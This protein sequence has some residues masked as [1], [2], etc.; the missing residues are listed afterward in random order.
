M[1]Q[2]QGARLAATRLAQVRAAGRARSY[3]RTMIQLR[4]GCCAAVLFLLASGRPAFSQVDGVVRD[5]Q[6]D[7]RP[8]EGMDFLDRI[9]ATDRW[10]NFPKFQET[11]EY[12]KGALTGIGLRNVEMISP[13]ADGVTQVGWWTMPLAW[14]VKQATLEIVEPSAPADMRYLA[15]YQ[16]IP[17]SL[18][19]WS[20]PTPPGGIT[21]DVVELRSLNQADI[22]K[23]DLKGKIVLVYQDPSSHKL[24]LIRKGAVG[25][26]S[27]ATENP[28][29]R[30]GHFWINAWGDQGWG[31]IKSSTPLV[32]FSITP[33]Q[34]EYISGILARG[35][36]VRVKAVADTRY[37]AG[38][39]P[40]V[41]GVIPG[42]TDEEVLVLGHT[43]EQGANDNGSG[44]AVMVEAMATLRR[45]IDAGTLKAPRRGIRILAMPE[46]YGSM[47]YIT[48]NPERMR[49]TVAAM[50]LDSPAGPY[51]AAGSEI[52]F[53][54]D[55]DVA[56]SYTDALVL[57]IA[58]TY[59]GSKR[60][61]RSVPAWTGPDGTDNYIF[62]PMIG[63]PTIW[64]RGEYPVYVHHNS[65]DTP[66][67][68]DAR[69][70]R[71]LVVVTASYLYYLASA[72]DAEVPWLAQ[73]TAS[74][75]LENIMHAAQPWLD[76]AANAKAEDLARV[77]RDG[78][79]HIAY[80]LDR[81]RAAVQSTLRLGTSASHEKLN[82]SLAPLEESLQRFA[83]EQS[84][85]LATAVNQ[86]AAAVGATVP[87][88]PLAP[89]ELTEASHLI[90]KRK[91]P[92]TITLDELPVAQREGQP[93]ASWNG[94]LIEALNW[95]DGK[96]TVADVIRLTTLERGSTR[97][98]LVSWFRFLARH[99]Y[100]DLV[101]VR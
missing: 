66:Q 54:M 99:G 87:V 34:G 98:D 58:E 27:A 76:R 19:M 7:V 22:D 2:E 42:S 41:T 97:V 51:D 21:A 36:R 45:L 43:A 75:G 33:R 39:Y 100:L 79:E 56:R 89:V 73:L 78:Q 26:I 25:V 23:A 3:N 8:A 74:R 69:S 37:Y 101:E 50:C 96:R 59:F 4:Y 18:G 91:R 15:D 6:S 62:D 9:Y 32:C 72:S 94:T 40:Y 85:R 90:V 20:S 16:K 65:Y 60:F 57:R 13:P 5:V 11:A 52:T 84:S 17:T 71:D 44:V 63:V 68:V 88:K 29:L 80:S 55:A 70:V 31:Y 1:F 30:D 95:C 14:D 77:L 10:F 61:W 47:A 92:G 86:R 24:P 28:N 67:T 93:D 53:V 49:R 81:D 64:T 35:G 82:A 83:A 46:V 48:A 12:L 38:T